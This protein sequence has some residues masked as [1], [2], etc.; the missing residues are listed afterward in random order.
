MIC[1]SARVKVLF[2]TKY[3]VKTKTKDLVHK[4]IFFNN[5]FWCGSDDCHL[6][7]FR[8]I[9]GVFVFSFMQ[10]VL[11]FSANQNNSA[12]D[13]RANDQGL[14]AFSLTCDTQLFHLQ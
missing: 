8:S 4:K 13:E 7:I 12:C 10:Q 2:I 1:S 11:D 9:L 5:L 3:L 6:L 14:V